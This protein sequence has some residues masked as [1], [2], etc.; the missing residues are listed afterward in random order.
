MSATPTSS[1]NLP[2]RN[3]DFESLSDSLDYAAR[4]EAG[5]NFYSARG[6]LLR[7]LPYREMRERAIEL[8]R[9]LVGAGL[10]KGARFALLADT[11]ADFMI[12]FHACQYAGLVPV[13]VALPT[14]LGGRA[15]YVAGLR[16]Q[17]ESCA[18]AAVMAP[19]ELLSFVQEA[20]EGLEISLVGGAEDFTELPGA[21]NELRPFGGEE[22]SYLQYSSGS[23]RQPHGIE[24]P[25]RS[26]I[27]NGLAIARHGLAIGAGDRCVSWLPLYH[28]MGLV[29]FMLVPVLTQ[30]SVD[31]IAT[32]DFARRPLQWL[33]LIG[34]G[35]ATLSF[36]PSFGYDL[37]TRRAAERS[38]E[39]I[40]LSTWRGAGI[41]GDMVQPEVLRRFAETFG[42][43]GFDPRAFVPSYGLAEA[44]L[45]FSFSPLGQGVQSDV[46]SRSKLFDHRHAE[47]IA[48][49]DPD[50]REIVLCGAPLPGHQLEVRDPAGRALPDRRVGHV[51]IKG[52]S[53]MIGYFNEPET[54]AELL[55][56]DGWLNTGDLGYTVEGALVITGRAKDLILVN[57]RNIWPQDLEWAVEELEQV[58]RGDAAA[59]SIMEAGQE[60]RVVLLVQCRLRDPDARAALA[61]E[62][63]GKVR[64]TA[65]VETTVGLIPHRDLPKTS[66]GKLS[67]TRARQM[68]L[69]GAFGSETA[70]LDTPASS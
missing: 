7:A 54:T 38:A 47:P 44:T 34:R 45:A 32:R 25:Q 48:A 11:T 4:G 66:S 67:R 3:A 2:Y 56:P 55:S 40:D 1:P 52:P 30:R 18:A 39:A 53:L 46:I 62:V 23:T 37:C 57:G 15:T 33:S 68:Y 16:R 31:Y 8:A 65:G 6:E 43:C 5:V 63:K 61:K 12:F 22:I 70:P 50:A 60:D 59:F 69:E 35:G 24:I 42:S 9:G 26:L 49:E 41:G 21:G 10:P 51:F 20:A 58:R 19:A 13:P 17:L 14:T 29:G 64:Q 27:A 28:D 36:S